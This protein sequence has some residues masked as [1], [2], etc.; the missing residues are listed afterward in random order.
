MRQRGQLVG[1]ADSP[2]LKRPR[3]GA[4]FTF[5]VAAANAFE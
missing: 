2:F 1:R 5:V 4:K 3:L